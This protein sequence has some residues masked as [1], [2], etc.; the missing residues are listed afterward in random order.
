MTE[1]KN[2]RGIENTNFFEQDKNF[3]SLLESLL[4]PDLKEE[5]FSSLDACGSLVAGR[6]NDLANL[7]NR[8]ENEPRIVKFDRSGNAVEKIDFGLPVSLLRKEVA[9]FGILTKSKNHLH[10]FA[11]V[12]LLAHNGESSLTCPISCTDGL[13]EVLKAKGSQELK[14]K[15]LPKI[16]STEM[17]FAGAQFVT[18]RDAGS[19]VGAITTTAMQM[20]NERWQ[21]TGD[22]WFCS[23]PD[24]F[25]VV[26]ARVG[27]KEGTR[28]VGLFFVPRVL[29]GGV[30]NLSLLRLKDKFGTR[31]LPTA[32]IRF[33]NTIGFPIGS[34]DEGFKT[35]MNYVLNVSRI[36]NSVNACGF[37]HR[38]ILEAEN[39]ARQRVAFGQAI[40]NY[41][42]VQETLLKLQSRLCLKLNLVFKLIALVDAKGLVPSDEDQAMW[43]R[44]LTNLA[45]YRTAVQLTDSVKE[46]I[47]LFGGNGIVEDFT[48]LPRLL[49]DAMIIET[50]E[51][52]H[53]TLCLQIIRDMKR[54][55]LIERFFE[56]VNAAIEGWHGNIALEEKFAAALNQT[57][58]Q[59][60]NDSLTERNARRVVDRLGALLEIAWFAVLESQRNKAMPLAAI[61]CEDLL[62]GKNL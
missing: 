12:Y 23:N 5:I 52:T 14:E 54:S 51:G 19:D 56:E 15:Y 37:L 13:I 16:I 58:G 49:R 20:T 9:E 33:E 48:I 28:G 62:S 50:W 43:Q 31:A 8:R 42:L 10:K 39:Y 36:H 1:L 44:F 32:E 18:E 40:I 2:F 21:I 61:A 6:W 4:L 53:N 59:I 25:F 7:A 35:L 11:L 46:T 30:N 22:K 29:D 55:N 26:A 17:P 27:E 34:P 41:P 38:A 57:R 24:E 3:Q 47:L 45:K 60:T